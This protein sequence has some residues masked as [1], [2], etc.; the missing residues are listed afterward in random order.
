MIRVFRPKSLVKVAVLLGLGL[1]L[2]VPLLLAQHAQ[3]SAAIESSLA[4]R[5][6]LED[7]LLEAIDQL[8][9]GVIDAFAKQKSIY[10]RWAWISEGHIRSYLNQNGHY[11]EQSH[12]GLLL[13]LDERFWQQCQ[14]D[15]KPAA[16]VIMEHI[17][18][19]LSHMGFSSASGPRG[20]WGF[21]DATQVASNCWSLPDASITV[22]G[23]TF[24]ANDARE[25]RVELH[26][27]TRLVA[28]PRMAKTWEYTWRLGG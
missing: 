21:S 12:C 6:Q 13:E 19:D 10:G 28:A 20:G 27:E 9:P 26:I 15:S 14:A 8:P 22:V 3:R 16:C 5:R 23:T 4:T 11:E 1:A 17:F 7:A 18:Q 2:C 25:V 24:V